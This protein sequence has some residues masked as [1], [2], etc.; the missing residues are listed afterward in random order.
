MG[1]TGEYQGSERRKS[2]LFS[3]IDKPWS[4]PREAVRQRA[5]FEDGI[6]EARMKAAAVA[7]P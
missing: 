1:E 3:I 7:Q 5:I 2:R 6:L 4:N